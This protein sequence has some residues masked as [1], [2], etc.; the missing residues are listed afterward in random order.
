MIGEVA[1]ER[2]EGLRVWLG[3]WFPGMCEA[4]SIINELIK[5]WLTLERC[6]SSCGL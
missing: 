3:V 6:F 2:G 4:T 5:M 1:E